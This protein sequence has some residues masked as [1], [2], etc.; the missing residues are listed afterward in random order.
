MAKKIYEINFNVTK[1]VY[2]Q[3]NNQTHTYFDTTYCE[4]SLSPI[5]SFLNKINEF[6]KLIIH[7][8]LD[9]TL[10]SDLKVSTYNL[11]LLG[12][13]SAVESYI[14]EI[15]R[16]LIISDEYSYHK[17]SSHNLSF[18][19]AMN[20]DKS[21]LPEAL[22]EKHSMAGKYNITEALKE[23]LGI[24]K[25]LTDDINKV[26]ED[27]NKVCQLRHCMIHRFGKLGSNNAIRLGLESHL[28]CLEKPLALEQNHL[29]DTYNACSNVV[30]AINNFLFKKI[31]TRTIENDVWTWDLRKDKAKF[32]VYFDL[33][34]SQSLPDNLIQND[35]NTCY[36]FIRKSKDD[37][38][39]KQKK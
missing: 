29:Y 19:A 8:G 1:A 2:S 26:L 17:C 25:G 11:V 5:D 38:L 13:I 27:F 21:I 10:S 9:T 4:N 34:I 35:L 7:I 12:Q 33:F 24:S 15:I 28:E 6:N 18:G 23:F 14:R 32:K 20:Y 36:K 30:I 37:F 3:V 16:K 22:M 39:Q 31:L